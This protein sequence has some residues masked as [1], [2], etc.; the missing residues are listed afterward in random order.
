MMDCQNLDFSPAVG[1]GRRE[2]AEIALGRGVVTKI[3]TL[4]LYWLGARRPQIAAVLGIAENSLRTTVRVVVKDGVAGL[5]DRRCSHSQRTFLPPPPRPAVEAVAVVCEDGLTTI[6]FGAVET[7]LSIPAPNWLQLRVVFLSLVHSGLMSAGDAADVLGLTPVHVRNL[8]ARLAAGDVEA[9]L[10]KRRGQQQ[11]YVLT[12][13]VKSEIVLQ[14]SANAVTGRS[15][16][17]RAIVADIGER[18]GLA[19]S[20]RTLR[21]C[22]SKLGLAKLATSLPELVERVKKGSRA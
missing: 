13:D 5:E 20:A 8:S 15:T 3:L 21:H 7:P 9:L 2:K 22:I 11:E 1:A 4:A 17:S 18:C 14:Y 10:D 6:R 16:S 12:P 19:V